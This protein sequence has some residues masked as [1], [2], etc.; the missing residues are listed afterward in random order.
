MFSVYFQIFTIVRSNKDNIIR[1]HSN[2]H[3]QSGSRLVR[4]ERKMII[5]NMSGQRC[6]GKCD[7]IA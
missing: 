6:L 2:L 7:E 5:D 3:T 4:V 1:A